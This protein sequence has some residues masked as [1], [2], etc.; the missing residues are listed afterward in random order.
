MKHECNLSELQKRE[1]F[2]QCI[3]QNVNDKIMFNTSSISQKNAE[4]NELL[5]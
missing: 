2:R 4:K 3:I 5:Y 1:S